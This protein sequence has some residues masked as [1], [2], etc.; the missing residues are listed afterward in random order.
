MPEYRNALPQLSGDPF[1]TD[2]GLETTLIFREGQELPH[3]AAFHLMKTAEGERLLRKY[4][5]TYAALATR[6]EAGLILESVTWRANTDWGRK[7]GYDTRGLAEV[8]S[9]AVRQL[10][11]IREEYAD[12]GAP[13]VLSGC[14]GPRGDGYV[15]GSLM[16]AQEAERYHRVQIDTLADTACDLVSAFTLNYVEEAIGIARAARKANIPVVISF[17][18]ETDGHLPTGQTLG[19]AIRQV[20]EATSSYPAY[21]MLNC[22]HPSHIAGGVR[23]GEPWTARLRGLR[24]NASRMSH[25]ELNE[26]PNLDAGDPV[27]LGHECAALAVGSLPHVNVFGGCCGT[28]DRHVEHIAANCLGGRG[29]RLTRTT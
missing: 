17:T 28:D 14:I 25:A 16:S 21:F 20:D 10:E 3:F 15:P 22:A 8:N 2:G 7:L 19:D 5:R 23:G 13:I 6:F 11:E 27:E 4:F 9:R 26:A 29:G 18:L 24:V 1:L 12:S